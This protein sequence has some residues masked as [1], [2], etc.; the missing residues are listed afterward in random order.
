MADLL[1]TVAVAVF[2]ALWPYHNPDPLDLEL[3]APRACDISAMVYWEGRSW[4]VLACRDLAPRELFFRLLHELGHVVRGHAR[5]TAE[6]GLAWARAAVLGVDEPGP[7]AL[8]AA[9]AA[10][11]SGPQLEQERE[12]SAWAQARMAEYWPLVVSLAAELKGV[13]R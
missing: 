2:K 12:A 5:K 11:E 9:L 4:H 7:R 6:P 8:R 1:T 10:C 13:C 3:F